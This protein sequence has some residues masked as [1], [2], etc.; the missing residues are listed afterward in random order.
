MLV[1]T[2][3]VGTVLVGTVLVGTVLVGTVL[4]GTLLVGTVLVGTLLVGTVL[5]VMTDF[6]DTQIC[7]QIK[8]AICQSICHDFTHIP[9]FHAHL[10][11]SS[12]L[13]YMYM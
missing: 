5:E 3:L 7:M 2:V 12:Y 9:T 10:S 11:S 4:V 13:K 1:G 8:I 6:G